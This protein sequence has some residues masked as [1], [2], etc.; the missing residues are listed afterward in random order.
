MAPKR[1]KGPSCDT[2]HSSNEEE[3]KRAEYLKKNKA[4][5]AKCRQKRLALI[6]ELDQVTSF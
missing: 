5:A 1:S 4:A 3:R 6:D 2:G